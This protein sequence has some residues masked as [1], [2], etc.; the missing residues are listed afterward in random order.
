M[1]QGPIWLMGFALGS[2]LLVL[3]ITLARHKRLDRAD[4]GSIFVSMMAGFSIPKAIFLCAYLLDPDPIEVTTKLRGYEKE[5][6]AAGAIILFLAI[7]SLWSICEKA[8]EKKADSENRTEVRRQDDIEGASK[9][10]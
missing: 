6:F 2:A 10:K 8:Y 4:A 9:G 5:I 3:L 1:M 7:A